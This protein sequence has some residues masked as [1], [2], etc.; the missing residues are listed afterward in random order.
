MRIVLRSL[1]VLVGAVAAWQCI[2]LLPV[3]TWISRPAAVTLG[4]TGAVLF[5]LI[6]VALC[7]A[8]FYWLGRLKRK[9]GLQPERIGDAALAGIVLAAGIIVVMGIAL[10]VPS[11]SSPDKLSSQVPLSDSAKASNV[12]VAP[13]AEHPEFVSIKFQCQGTY[14]DYD[15]QSSQAVPVS[16]VYV[17]VSSNNVAVTGSPGFDAIYLIITR[18]DKGIGF[19]FESNQDYSGFFN[20][21]DGNID[22]LQKNGP[23]QSDGSFKVHKAMQLACE[24]ANPLF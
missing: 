15:G 1:R 9:H 22:I 11:N 8:A 21:L 4:M 20:R 2:G 24:K 7:V 3:F 10:L 18:L 6:I 16:G 12:S 14:T 17:E 5:K 23:T 19:R 13:S